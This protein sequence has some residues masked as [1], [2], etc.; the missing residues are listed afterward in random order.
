MQQAVQMLLPTSEL[1]ESWLQLLSSLLCV[2]CDDG[3][4][5]QVCSAQSK[6]SEAQISITQ[7]SLYSPTKPVDSARL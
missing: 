3:K 6:N 4:E 5:G 1:S 2:S 7:E